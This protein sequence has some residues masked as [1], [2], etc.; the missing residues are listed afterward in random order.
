MAH[1]Y[2]KLPTPNN[3]NRKTSVIKGDIPNYS[4]NMKLFVLTFRCPV[5]LKDIKIVL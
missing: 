4:V 2:W 5:F 1:G 3:C